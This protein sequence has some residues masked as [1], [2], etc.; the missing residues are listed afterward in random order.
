MHRKSLRFS[1]ENGGAASLS[2]KLVKNKESPKSGQER[3]QNVFR[4]P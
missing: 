2:G 3:M 4:G 1:S